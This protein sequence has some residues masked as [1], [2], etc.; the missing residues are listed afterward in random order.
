MSFL[1][2]HLSD[3]H[4]GPLPPAR[5]HELLGKRLTGYINWTRGRSHLHDM[6]VL[7]RLVTDMRHQNPGHIAMTGDILNLGLPAEFPLA[8]D[9]LATLGD[10][11]DVSFTPGNHDAYTKAIMPVL[12]RT[13]APW[14]GDSGAAMSHYPY[15]RVRGCVAL[16][17]LSSGVPTAPFIASGTLGFEQREAFAALLR[18]TRR[19]GLARVVLIHHPPHMAG[20]SRGRNL[21]D[22]RPF[23]KIVRAEGADLILHGH[24]HR[25]MVARIAGPE[26]AVPVVGVASAS[27]VP[28]T[29]GH[30]G[31]YHLFG[32]S[33]S[34]GN[35]QVKGRAR[36][37]MPGLAEIGEL[38]DLRL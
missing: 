25:Q 3:A 36:G 18:Q 15:L 29:P 14:T 26:G 31:A 2:A 5:P 38:G 7:A 20:A 28:G 9:W 11:A 35:W 23:E 4:I 1:L 13:F 21:T 16:I 17:G 8:R 30:R 33:G 22:A 32:I 34:S 12:A 6:A 37:L 27:A 19:D 10:P 24:N